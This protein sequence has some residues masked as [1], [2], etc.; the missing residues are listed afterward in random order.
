MTT[1]PDERIAE[2]EA[3]RDQIHDRL[4]RLETQLD[5]LHRELS[6]E[7]RNTERAER[8]L[9]TLRPRFMNQSATIMEQAQQLR[10]AKADL[11]QWE[12]AFERTA[13][14]DMVA[15]FNR[16]REIKA[17]RDRLRA[18]EDPIPPKQG[19][20]R[21]AGQWIYH[22]NTLD[23]ESRLMLAGLILNALHNQSLPLVIAERDFLRSQLRDALDSEKKAH[24]EVAVLHHHI[25]EQKKII[26][27]VKELHD[28][29]SKI[30]GYS[31]LAD[32]LDV[33]LS[34]EEN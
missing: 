20:Q 34:P 33:A 13:L 6:E 17:E 24:I 27:R 22:W 8:E 30:P 25:G 10:Q 29:W 2:L 31:E 21:S 16:L 1:H 3:E 28:R 19:F 14:P 26:Q 11:E 23:A 12:A 15:E 32:D 4:S 18:G 5:E 7:R 9:E